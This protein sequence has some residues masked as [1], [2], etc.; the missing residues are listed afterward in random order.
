MNRFNGGEIAEMSVGNGYM[1]RVQFV[2]FTEILPMTERENQLDS[3]DSL[4][5]AIL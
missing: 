4:L 3:D 2:H 5:A 1:A